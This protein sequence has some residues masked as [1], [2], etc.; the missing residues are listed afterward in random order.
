MSWII[1]SQIKQTNKQTSTFA[2]K[3][4]VQTE[5]VHVGGKSAQDCGESEKYLFGLFTRKTL[6]NT[7]NSKLNL[8]FNFTLEVT[9]HLDDYNMN[10][11][12]RKIKLNRELNKQSIYNEK[13]FCLL[14][15]IIL[16]MDWLEKSK[17]DKFYCSSNIS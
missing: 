3:I 1:W 16:Y 11:I 10:I 4:R 7:T 6:R 14:N 2:S 9:W 15:K 17:P 5:P 8:W 12:Y 13:S